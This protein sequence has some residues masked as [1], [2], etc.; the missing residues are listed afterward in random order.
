[1]TDTTRPHPRVA[2]AAA[3]GKRLPMP[4]GELFLSEK[5]VVREQV[6]LVVHFHG[7]PWLIEQHI[8]RSAPNAA[9]L[10]VNLGAGSSRYAAP[11]NDPARFR[12]LLDEAAS[13]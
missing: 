9:L 11:F 12:S 2:E 8:A 4:L 7:E 1:M 3:P 6:P 10:A 13:G 5:F